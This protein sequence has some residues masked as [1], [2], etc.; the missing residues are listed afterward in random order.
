MGSWLIVG[1][2][3]L[4][5]RVLNLRVWS[6]VGALKN[7]LGYYL[8]NH[9]DREVVCFFR[10]SYDM[11]TYLYEDISASLVTSNVNGS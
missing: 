8:S 9:L 11:H 3:T 5:I 10:T 2:L 4:Y 6:S 7:H 1:W